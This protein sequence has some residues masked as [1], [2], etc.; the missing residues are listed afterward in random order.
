MRADAAHWR[1]SGQRVGA[2]VVEEDRS[3]LPDGVIVASLGRERD[4][5][6]AAA[7]L[8]SGLRALDAAQVDVIVARDLG[9]DGLGLAIWDRLYRAAEGRVLDS[10][11]E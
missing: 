11:Q 4:L 6:E 5:A 2:L 10:R 7:R 1:A 9:R 3:L 8:F